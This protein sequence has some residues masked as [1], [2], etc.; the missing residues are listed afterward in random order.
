MGH[1]KTSLLSAALVSAI[2]VAAIV[3]CGSSE[4]PSTF[5]PNAS[6]DGSTSDPADGSFGGTSVRD[7]FKEPVL[8]DGAPSNA[9]DVF[10]KPDVT[11]TTGGGAATGPCLYE[12]EMGSLFPTNWLRPR[13]RFVTAEDENLF[14]IEMKVPNQISPLVV[15]TTKNGYILDKTRWTTVTSTGSGTVHVTV[16]SAKVDANGN[17]LAGPFK[18]TE[19]DIE[20]APPGVEASGSVLYWTTSNGTVLKGF[21]IGDETVQDVIT[22]N[23][24]GTFCV[25]CH[26]STPDGRYA[27]LNVSPKDDGGGPATI[28]IRSVDG[29]NTEPPFLTDPAKALLARPNQ[30]MPTFSKSHWAD[31]DRTVLSLMPVANKTEILWTDLEA[32]SGDQGAGWGVVQRTGDSGDAFS[33]S[34]SHDGTRVVYVSTTDTVSGVSEYGGRLF[35]VPYAN[36]AGGAATPLAGASDAT[37]NQFYPSFSA[38]DGLVAFSRAPAG[39]GVKD[40]YY[41][42]DT[43]VFVV[44]ES[45]GSAT[46][47][48]ANDPPACLKGKTSPGIKNS[49]PKWSPEVKV[50]GD[51]K[52]YFLV[53]SSLRNPSSHG[54][55]LYVAPIV[56]DGA[57]TV[58]TYAALM[59]WNQ[60]ET[61]NN[62]TPAWDAFQLAGPN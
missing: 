7:D 47:L 34:F 15:Y 14:R 55:Q 26:T 17:V 20:I 18:G 54:P 35:T 56:V 49:W 33:P 11:T 12:P 22:P 61:E 3:A 36:R 4:D 21:R 16:R 41:T 50:A 5:D 45:G 44:P 30:H 19:G 51:K 29:K 60:P 9:A 31:G 58:K 8:D 62:H 46:R 37:Y 28:T 40:S 42:S 43:E 32:K 39:S 52:Y 48:T 2:G 59:L 13:F 27:G 1:A 38:D 24:L 25:G 10:A 57:G 53:F 23:A 6:P